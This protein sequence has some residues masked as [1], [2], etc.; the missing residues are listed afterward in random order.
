MQAES[1]LQNQIRLAISKEFGPRVT[2]FR[3]A[4]GKHQTDTGAWVAYGLAPGSPDLVGWATVD[5]VARFV[6]IEVKV[7]G[8]KPRA[9]Q[10]HFLATVQA[11]GGIAGCACSVEEALAILHGSMPS[12]AP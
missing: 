7:P 3:N 10:A 12:L 4:V 8:Q 5:G 6:A 9:D 1:A 2:L 11:A